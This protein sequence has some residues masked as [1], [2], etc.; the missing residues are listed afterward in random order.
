MQ[1]SK[2][3][4]IL[5]AEREGST[6]CFPLRFLVVEGVVNKYCIHSVMCSFI[7]IYMYVFRIILYKYIHIAWKKKLSTA[8]SES[9]SE[10]ELITLKN[11]IISRDQWIFLGLSSCFTS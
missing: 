8:L 10:E 4:S 9:S 5:R 11:I 3:M 6:V 1:C 7:E 2:S